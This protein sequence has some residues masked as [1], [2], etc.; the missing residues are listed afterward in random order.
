MIKFTNLTDNFFGQF[1]ESCLR[2]SANLGIGETLK[3][4]NVKKTCFMFN[5]HDHCIRIYAADAVVPRPV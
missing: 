4:F 2:I 5:N 1:N 3:K